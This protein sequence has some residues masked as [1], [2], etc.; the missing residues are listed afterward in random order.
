MD[1]GE[2]GDYYL[3][4]HCHHQNDSCI[5]TSSDESHCNVSLIVR[6]KV[7]RHAVS[8]NDNLFE[9]KYESR[10]GIKPRSFCSTID[11]VH[12]RLYNMSASP[13][14]FS[15]VYITKVSLTSRICVSQE[16]SFLSPIF[17]YV[18]LWGELLMTYFSVSASDVSG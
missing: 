13:I 15:R 8:T 7:T 3:S 1:E 2:G 4:L 6:D 18:C 10:S 9:E 14:F 12:P 5:K 16:M 11:I 17:L